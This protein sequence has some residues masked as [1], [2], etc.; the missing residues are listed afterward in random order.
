MSLKAYFIHISLQIFMTTFPSPPS[1]ICNSIYFKLFTSTSNRV[2]YEF[3]VLPLDFFSF[4]KGLRNI[5]D[6]EIYG[7]APLKTSE[8]KSK[9]KKIN[10]HKNSSRHL[11]SHRKIEMSFIRISPHDITIWRRRKKRPLKGEDIKPHFVS[12][13]ISLYAV[14]L[15]YIL[16]L[17]CLTK[18]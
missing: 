1:Y 6:M 4:Q 3:Y 18:D 7:K 2:H 10:R 13:F 15:R 8:M 14:H 12:L 17:V 9:K 16:S 11:K 5:K